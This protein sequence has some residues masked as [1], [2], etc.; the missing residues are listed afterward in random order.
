MEHARSLKKGKAEV[1]GKT[2][3]STSMVNTLKGQ[4]VANKAWPDGRNKVHALLEQLKA[5]DP[6]NFGK[7]FTKALS[8]KLGGALMKKWGE[9]TFP[10]VS[11]LSLKLQTYA[12][13]SSESDGSFVDSDNHE[14]SD[15]SD[16][17]EAFPQIGDDATLAAL[18]KVPTTTTPR[19]SS[20]FFFSLCRILS[21]LAS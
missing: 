3:W 12:K 5:Q 8:N 14:S 17:T 21:I 20:R 2:E 4:I 16:D 7:M 9:K 13:E 19:V 6:G 10:K 15:S 18:A 11:H 1:K